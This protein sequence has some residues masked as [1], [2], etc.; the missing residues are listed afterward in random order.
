VRAD[1]TREDES[2]NQQREGD[3]AAADM[4]REP[5]REVW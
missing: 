5:E 1:L 4:E 2:E 3:L